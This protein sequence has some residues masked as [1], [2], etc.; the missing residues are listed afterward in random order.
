MTIFSQIITGELPAYKIYE[1]DKTLAFLDIH[2]AVPG[3]VLVVPKVEVDQFM[4]LDNE[5][6]EALMMSAKYVAQVLRRAFP[7]AARVALQIEGLDIPHVHVKLF[8]FTTPEEL[9]RHADMNA[10]VD[11]DALKAVQARILAAL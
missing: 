3:Y 10:P 11:H 5:Y 6:Y 7:E 9:H 8:P 2:P 1:D 4:D